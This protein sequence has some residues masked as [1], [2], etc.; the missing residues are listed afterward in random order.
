[1]DFTTWTREDFLAF[2][3]RRQEVFTP[4]PEELEQQRLD[5]E[6]YM[7]DLVEQ[8]LLA[9][10]ITLTEPI[11]REFALQLLELINA[12]QF[13]GEDL[14]KWVD[15]QIEL[16]DGDLDKAFKQLVVNYL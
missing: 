5:H 13:I 7:N 2:D 3:A 14:D 15:S 16:F 6:Q 9:V 8:K 1:M 4:T 10:G 12:R 11:T